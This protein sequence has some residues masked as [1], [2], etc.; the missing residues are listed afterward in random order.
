M[1]QD[2]AHRNREMTEDRAT[3]S[4]R[5]RSG[6]LA[7]SFCFLKLQTFLRERERER[8]REGEET[9]CKS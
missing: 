5:Q 8:G 7:F 6:A 3:K 9:F 4:L 2:E 1:W